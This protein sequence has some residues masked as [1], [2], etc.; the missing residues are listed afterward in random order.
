MCFHSIII[1][2]LVGDFLKRHERDV[3]RCEYVHEVFPRTRLHL[4]LIHDEGVSVVLVVVIGNLSFNV[5][6]DV[7]VLLTEHRAHVDVN[8]DALTAEV[9]GHGDVPIFRIKRDAVR[10]MMVPVRVFKIVRH[11]AVHEDVS[12][13][14]D[15]DVPL[16]E[17]DDAHDVVHV[18]VD[19][20]VAMFP[21]LS[22]EAVFKL[23]DAFVVLHDSMKETIG[24][25]VGEEQVLEGVVFERH[26]TKLMGPDFMWVHR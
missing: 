2:L 19:V 9:V 13:G 8:D 10:L 5:S 16:V 17:F 21:N 11:P 18:V 26:L 14:L 25:R 23:G 6:Q 3:V 22:K 1:T 24:V 7:G 4:A 15:T 20:H 12:F